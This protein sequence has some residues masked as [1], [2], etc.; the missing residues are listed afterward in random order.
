MHRSRLRWTP[1]LFVAVVLCAPARAGDTVAQRLTRQNALV[2]ENWEYRL[3]AQPEMATVRGDPR[4]GDRW[5]DYGL[6]RVERHRR[7]IAGQL[8]R[9]KAIDTRGFG[10]QD[11]LN[12]ALLA[13]ELSQTLRELEL[14]T[15]LMPVDHFTGA[16]F[17]PAQ[18]A[19]IV[20]LDTPRQRR[21][22]VERLRRLPQ[23]FAQLEERM[24]HGRQR[25]LMPPRASLE[26]VVEQCRTIADTPAA[27]SVFA[28]A[29]ARLPA[30]LPPSE[31]RQWRDAVLDAI[32][33]RVRPAYRRLADVVAT[34]HVPAA[35][36][37]PGLWSLPDGDARYRF[38][39]LQQ[40]TLSLDPEAIHRIGLAEVARIEAEQDGIARR[41][42]HADLAALRH[43]VRTDRR[44]YAE[45]REQI[46]QRYRDYTAQMATKLPT[47][48]GV[49]PATPMEVVP[50]EA[51][52][53]KTAAAAAYARGTPDG[54]RPGRVMVNT[55][56]HDKRLLLPIEAIA[57]HEG[58]PGHH[59][60]IAIAEALPA[61]P[62]FRR[63]AHHGAYVEGWALYA[64]RLAKEVGQ[65]EDPMSDYGRLSTE[66][67][68]AI[69]LVL[70]TGVHH[71][72]WTREQMVAYFRAHSTEDEP[73]IEAET[74]RYIAWPAQALAYKVGEMKLLELRERAR[75]ALGERFDLRAFHDA[76]LAGGALP[77]DVLEARL[78]AWWTLL[79]PGSSAGS[80]SPAPAR[81][82]PA[83]APAS[84]RP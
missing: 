27:D 6:G 48:F 42:G 70:D 1:L 46:L 36:R 4:H 7:A 69:R 78:Q 9:L 8:K 65:Y 5:T 58:V 56:D 39:I 33:S 22:Y 16:H 53:E 32:D 66:L 30:T 40:T 76:V 51:Y 10:E 20:A 41:L 52:R 24:R 47:L 59:L 43:A 57:Y 44:F 82:S 77:L 29:L 83:A 71:K 45:S 26:K 62:P 68:R 50:V 35:R 34:D 79:T 80:S 73:S 28:S 12:H 15:H 31:Q 81:R 74:D 37:E 3:R 67:L 17:R 63:T 55:G 11:R 23:M 61:L 75:T 54:S 60:Q 38:A 19:A 72:R 13:R 21:D 64:E 25:G 18:I 84:P 49:L 2:A 14:G